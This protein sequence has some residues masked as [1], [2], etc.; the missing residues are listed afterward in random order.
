ME[1]KTPFN[2]TEYQSNYYKEHKDYYKDYYEKNKQKIKGQC[3]NA[4]KKRNLRLI[5]KKLNEDKF[6][7]FPHSKL[8]KYKIIFNEEKQCYEVKQD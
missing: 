2:A 3:E 5:I 8:E 1:N 6:K 7:R 4:N